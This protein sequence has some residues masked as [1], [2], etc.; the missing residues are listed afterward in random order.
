MTR[1]AIIG[2]GPCGLSQLQAFAH[3]KSSGADVPEVVCF[4]KQD[5][6]GGLWH[7]TWRTGLDQYGEPV[8]GSMYRYL[9][10]NGPKECLECSDY[11]FDDHFGKP[12]PSFPPREVLHDYITGRVEKSGVKG[13]IRFNTAVRHVAFD[14]SSQTFSVTVEDLPSKAQRT[15]SFDYVIVATGHFSVPNVPHF[16]GIESFPG[17]VL[18]GHDFRSADEFKGKDLVVV[19]GS[20]SAEDIG[21]QCKK[22]GAKSVTISYRSQAMGFDWPDGMKEVPLITHVDGR[23]VNFTDGSSVDADAIILCTGYLH[24]FPFLEDRLKLKTHNR[25]NP[26]GLYKGI[27]WLDNP[28]LIYLGM[29]D[30]FYTFSMFDA[31]AWYARDVILGRIK[32]PSKAEM[33]ADADKWVAREEKLADPFAQ[34]DFQTDYTKELVAATDYPDFDL[35]MVADLFKAWEH[36]KEHSITGYRDK[37]FKSPCT[38]TMAPVHHTPWVEAMDDSM[39]TFLATKPG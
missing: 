26:P 12:I 15:E 16:E 37:A 33:T 38:G 24:H 22:Y 20:Y 4:D 11:T 1:V 7:Y 5:D 28:K 6:W 10:S 31:Q 17:R 3:A 21:L 2:A 19:G 8:H 25:M 18:H 30:Q 39:A 36:D 14:N 29:Q 23:S 34:I 35:D 32:L 27:F 13:Q 9:W